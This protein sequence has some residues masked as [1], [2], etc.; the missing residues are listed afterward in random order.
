MRF[1]FLDL[2]DRIDFRA[3]AL[4]QT[5]LCLHGRF[6]TFLEAML[7]AFGCIPNKKRAN[8]VRVARP[9]FDFVEE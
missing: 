5:F 7:S 1:V 2:I 9:L 6:S 3:N 4:H 8:P